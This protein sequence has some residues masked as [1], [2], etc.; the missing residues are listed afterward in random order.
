LRV[1]RQGGNF[2][3]FNF[4]LGKV[5]PKFRAKKGLNTVY[6]GEREDGVKFASLVLQQSSCKFVT[7]C[8]ND[9]CRA[10][11]V[12][13]HTG[14]DTNVA[15]GQVKKY[16][17]AKTPYVEFPNKKGGNFKPGHLSYPFTCKGTSTVRFTVD[18][19]ANN[20]GDDS[21]LI[22][23]DQAAGQTQISKSKGVWHTGQGGN[24][25]KNQWKRS[26][27]S[28]AFRV[29]KG[30]HA[31]FIGER[32]DGF[33]YSNIR[34]HTAGSCSFIIPCKSQRPIP[35]N[36][37]CRSNS[38]QAV[39]GM[40]LASVA[41]GRA[42]VHYHPKTPFMTFPNGHGG[43]FKTGYLK[44]VFTCSKA[45]SVSFKARA[46]GASG[47]D[48]SLLIGVDL[49]PKITGIDRNKGLWHCCGTGKQKV[50]NFKPSRESK[51]FS[52]SK[53]NHELYIGERED[54]ILLSSF[55]LVKGKGTCKFAMTC[56]RFN[57]CSCANGSGAA[58]SKCPRHGS[59][60]C[61]SCRAFPR[62]WK[63]SRGK[64][65]APVNACKCFGGTAATGKSCSKHGATICAKCNRGF[66]KVG[67]TCRATGATKPCRSHV[68]S[69]VKG[70]DAKVAG[71]Q[72]IKHLKAKVPYIS[73][74]NGKGGNFKGGHLRYNFVCSKA[75]TVNF[76]A[77]TIGATGTDDSLLIDVD[78]KGSTVNKNTGTWH[79]GGTGA[80][81]LKTMT[82]RPSKVSKSFKVSAGIHS[83]H[84]SEREDGIYVSQF[85]FSKGAGT[86]RFYVDCPVTP[87]CRSTTVAAVDGHDSG[88]AAGNAVKH[89]TARV[90]YVEF[91]DGKGNFKHGYLAYPFT[92]TKPTTVSFTSRHIANSGTQDSML[93][94]VNMDPDRESVDRN[95]GAWHSGQGGNIKTFTFVTG[96]TSKSFKVGKGLSTMYI[97]Q[98]E[99]G[100]RIQSFSFKAGGGICQFVTKCPNHKC[101]SKSI[102]ALAGVD[103][104]VANGQV[105]KFFTAKVPYVEFPNKKGGNFK[106]GSLSYPFTCKGK[107]KVSFQVK[108]VANNGN[109][110]SVLIDVD[111]P[112]GQVAVNKNK[113]VWHT[114]QGGNIKT[115]SFKWSRNSKTF[116]VGPG[117]HALYISEREDGFRFSEFRFSKAGSCSFKTECPQGGALPRCRANKILAV[118]GDYSGVAAG[119]ATVH[120]Q[121]TDKSKRSKVPYI[122]FPNGKGGNFKRGNLK[123]DF[124]C[125]K[126]T[127]VNF[128]AMTI[129]ATGTD[130]SI[131][132]DV[133]MKGSTVNKNTGTWHTGGTGAASLKTMTFK[134]SKPSKSFKV[135]A[136]PHT[137]HISER[138]DGILLSAF[139]IDKG[140]GACRFAVRCGGKASPC[141]PGQTLTKS[142]ALDSGK[143]CGGATIGPLS[144]QVKYGWQPGAG[145]VAACK[146]ECTKHPLCSSF[147]WRDSDRGCFWKTRTAAKTIKG[148]RGH[149]CYSQVGSGYCAVKGPAKPGPKC[150]CPNGTPATGASCPKNGAVA[151]AK[152]KAGFSV[153]QQYTLGRGLGKHCG[154]A[155]VG[156]LSQS[157][158]YGWRPGIGGVEACKAECTKHLLCT[159]FVWRDSDKGCFWKTNTTP[160]T[161]STL[162]GHHCYTAAG[163]VTCSR[164][165]AAVKTC[166]KGQVLTKAYAL[167]SGKHCGGNSLSG[168]NGLNLKKYGW[169]PGKGG[170]AACQRE[171]SSH[172]L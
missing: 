126:A 130:D 162:R 69:A 101:R 112:P 27:A 105:K 172:A 108:L 37:K 111:L 10:R 29:S 96:K 169:K 42:T 119:K 43:N 138:E 106:A 7:E 55:E 143:H 74:P 79:T 102:S 91:P 149:H 50:P 166:P 139:Q 86:C 19:I 142:Y 156:A 88:V 53:G 93:I 57:V 144:K 118:D 165:L 157:I 136:G 47:N 114:G 23:V 168:N 61:V 21:V 167:D 164:A 158:K 152:C 67:K 78:M 15:N 36:Y 120:L 26:K 34:F 99:D 48:D 89:M 52:V 134:L 8:P 51:R 97:S 17:G 12:A 71:G 153:S 147:V 1:R 13:A 63:L 76:R 115:F 80:G 123:Y 14:I 54:G 98:R 9:K 94:D 90:P 117:D 151:C 30:H 5:S 45:T 35:A 60:K 150:K 124:V 24:L 33:R 40:N 81:S 92:C 116:N 107:S 72:A 38:V 75:T 131:L 49:D 129:G 18:L 2:K 82:F 68:I 58:G 135:S 70:I 109:D 11:S 110:D 77:M 140:K 41:G 132:I 155:T 154:G 125:S 85:G 28:K 32:E 73:F 100:L 141:G 83:L 161:A 145:G 6:I 66:R 95:S 22:A 39:R 137:L 171:C 121:G 148:L 84:I 46:I 16:P 159:A 133:D 59:S 160:G 127:T 62:P 128:R 87:P 31:V 113:G 64:C 20:G 103:S 4:K 25:K 56:G 65:N 163:P 170:V 122:T 104:N 3:T 146:A 44:Y